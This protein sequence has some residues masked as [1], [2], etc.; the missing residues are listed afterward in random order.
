MPRAIL[1]FQLPETFKIIPID[2]P[3]G[4]IILQ[5]GMQRG[6]AYIWADCLTEAPIEKRNL[7][8]FA[9]GEEVPLNTK[10][11]KTFFEKEATFVW[12]LFEI[13]S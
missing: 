4:A 7:K 3:Q 5:A 6:V 9:T 13:I 8:I 11:I 10:H 12:H 1:K 2:I